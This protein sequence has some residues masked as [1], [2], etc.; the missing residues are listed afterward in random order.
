MKK[1]KEEEE[2]EDGGSANVIVWDCGSPLYDSYELVSLCHLI[3]RH[4]MSLPSQGESL[5]FIA[6]SNN[7]R[8]IVDDNAL[9]MNNSQKLGTLSKFVDKNMW[10]KMAFRG[11]QERP[12]KIKSLVRVY[13]GFCDTSWSM[14]LMSDIE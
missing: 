11:A 5:P 8:S 9:K 1:A 12:K 3:E 7:S 2:E 13:P 14:D 10:K 6:A 4:M